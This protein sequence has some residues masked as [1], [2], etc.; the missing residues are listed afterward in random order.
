[1]KQKLLLHTCCG[2]CLTAVA[3]KVENGYDATIYWFNPNIATAEEHAKRLDQLKL[4]PNELSIVVDQNYERMSLE[5]LNYTKEYANEQE[6]GKRCEKCFEFRL[7]ACAMAAKNGNYNLFTTTLSVSPHKDAEAINRIGQEIATEVGVEYLPAN[8]KKGNG[9][10]RSI[11]L[12]KEYGLYRQNFCG[13]IYS[14]D[15]RVGS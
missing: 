6:G 15:S 10:H 9:Y 12:A 11:I 2:P 5:W 4:F 3:E 8:F 14:R 13:C 1:M 7:R